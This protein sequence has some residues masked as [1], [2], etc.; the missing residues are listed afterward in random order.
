MNKKITKIFVEKLIEK[1]KL[2]DD[3]T[4]TSKILFYYG[5]LI[6]IKFQLA[7]SHKLI[8]Q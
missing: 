7:A 5:M 6:V 4:F 2:I 3:K 1:I 8:P